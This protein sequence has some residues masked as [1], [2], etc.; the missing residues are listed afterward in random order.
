VKE[1]PNRAEAW[2]RLADFR[3]YRLND[4]Q[5]ALEAIEPALYLDPHSAAVQQSFIAIRDRFRAEGDLPRDT[6]T[7]GAD[8]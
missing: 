5:G 2:L 1:H 8:E 7:P 4:H 3:L 6:V